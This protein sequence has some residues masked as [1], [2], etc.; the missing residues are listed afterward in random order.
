MCILMVKNPDK[1][2]WI[3]R[4]DSAF[5]FSEWTAFSQ[6]TRVDVRNVYGYIRTGLVNEFWWGYDGLSPE[7]V[8][9]SAR[10]Y[11]QAANDTL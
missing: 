3:Y 4:Q 8:I 6:M 7:V 9:N 1:D 11:Q 10:L 2:G 5:P